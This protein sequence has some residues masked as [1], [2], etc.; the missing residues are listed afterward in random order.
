[1]KTKQIV[2]ASRPNGIPT[3]DDFRSENIELDDLKK[4]EVLLKGLYY[5]VDPYMRGRMNEGKSYVAQFEL[6]QPIEGGVLAT[7]VKSKSELFKTGDTVLGALPWSEQMIASEKGLQKIESTVE[8]L[9][10]YLGILGMTGLTAY[11]GLMQIGKP[12]AG[13]TVVV[14][15]AAGAVGIVVGQLAKIQGARVIGIAGSDEKVKMLK[16][17]FGYDEVVN[18][19]TNTNMKSTIAKLCPNG[20]DVY[21]DNVGG[22]ISDAVIENL[23][24][25]SRIALCGQISLYNST[26]IPMGPRIQP[27][28]LTRSVLMQGFIINN[29][30]KDFPE[31]IAH[32]SKWVNEGKLKFIETIVEGFDQLPTALLGLFKGENNG[33]M[34][35][36]R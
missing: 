13:E 1:M 5:S 18:Y 31:G 36:K 35:V 27:M 32:L 9:T 22:S 15:G 29:F 20:V 7:V 2:L 19:K 16:E 14:S 6:D 11:F 4:G 24:F 10:Y 17:E 23:N 21:F 26:E 3:L 33:K 28:L 34:I 25:H 12:K 30:Q 8:S